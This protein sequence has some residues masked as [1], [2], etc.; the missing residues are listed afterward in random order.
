MAK[1]IERKFLVDKTKLPKLENGITIKQGYINTNDESVVRIRYTNEISYLTIK[2][3]RKGITRS[4]YEYEIPSNDAK[5]MLEELCHKI[6]IEKTRYIININNKKWE[7]DLFYGLNSNLIIA[8]VELDSE[9]EEIKIPNWVISEI[10]KDSKY[11]NKYLYNNP[12]SK[13]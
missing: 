13:W 5:E 4:E 8:E 11:T 2:G 10:S 7:I 1:E 6:Y 3:K 12:Y 9:D